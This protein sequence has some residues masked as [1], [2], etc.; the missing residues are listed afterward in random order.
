MKTILAAL[1]LAA[2]ICTPAFAAPSIKVLLRAEAAATLGCRDS[3]EPNSFQTQEEC[4]R[5]ERLV[6]RLTQAGMCY[7][8]KGQVGAE[9]HWHR[10]GPGSFQN[11]DL[12]PPRRP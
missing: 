9:M 12:R 1:A 5:R 2:S 6:G 8:K 10:C 4:H 3:D 11:D 7:G